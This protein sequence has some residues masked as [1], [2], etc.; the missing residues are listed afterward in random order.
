MAVQ[1]KHHKGGVSD[2][3][4]AG[5]AA[6]RRAKFSPDYRSPKVKLDGHLLQLFEWEQVIKDKHSSLL[7]VLRVSEYDRDDTNSFRVVQRWFSYYTHL[8]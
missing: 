3:Y 2:E 5:R 6:F 4:S 8:S 7:I 1:P